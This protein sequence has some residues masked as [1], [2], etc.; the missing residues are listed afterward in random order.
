MASTGKIN[1]SMNSRLQTMQTINDFF[2]QQDQLK[3]DGS[4]MQNQAVKQAPSTKSSA[5]ANN[6][7]NNDPRSIEG[8]VR[9]LLS[10]QGGSVKMPPG[11]N[12]NY[13]T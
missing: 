5:Q 10:E 9:A 3:T 12:V 1:E 13:V 6:D 2:R 4:L 7:P 8:S 11:E